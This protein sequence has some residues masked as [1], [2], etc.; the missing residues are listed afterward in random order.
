[1]T[2]CGSFD[3]RYWAVKAS[4]DLTGE[5]RFWYLGT[6]LYLYHNLLFCLARQTFELKF[7][8]CLDLDP[9]FL[10]EKFGIWTCTHDTE[11]CLFDVLVKEWCYS[12]IG[13]ST[14]SPPPRVSVHSAKALYVCQPGW[15]V[16][17]A[18]L[19][20]CCNRWSGVSSPI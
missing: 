16:W 18:C 4:L 20:P 2:I 6:L 15:H 11:S 19:Y 13:V 9:I 12:Y 10:R 3:L 8:C 14:P 1:M 17:L 5:C 7:T